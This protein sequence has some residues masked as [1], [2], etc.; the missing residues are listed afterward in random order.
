MEIQ[1]F[2]KKYFGAE[3]VEVQEKG[4]EITF[5]N[6]T[7]EYGTVSATAVITAAMTPEA[8]IAAIA[9]AM[10]TITEYSETTDYYRSVD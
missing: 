8:V 6:Y 3:S 7:S 4:I 1:Q 10:A 9:E 5:S 2:F